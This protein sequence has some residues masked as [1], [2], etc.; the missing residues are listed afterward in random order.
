M[1]DEQPAPEAAP[2]LVDLSTRPSPVPGPLTKP[3]PVIRTPKTHRR[4][5]IIIAVVVVLTGLTAGG[6]AWSN[7]LQAAP[8]D[9][10][11]GIAL[12]GGHLSS[13]LFTV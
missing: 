1:V 4:W 9:R 11:A 3:S 2:P 7:S 8:Q 13:L 12:G 6:I 10:P 5:V